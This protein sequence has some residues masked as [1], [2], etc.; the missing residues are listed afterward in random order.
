MCWGS[1]GMNWCV[2]RLTTGLRRGRP[3]NFRRRKAAESVG[4]LGSKNTKRSKNIGT[5]VD[6]LVYKMKN[7]IFPS[8]TGRR[9]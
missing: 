6:D 7:I 1:K 4:K 2:G 8:R 5:F 9:E 3:A